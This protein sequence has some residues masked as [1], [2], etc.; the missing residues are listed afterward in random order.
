MSLDFANDESTTKLMIAFYKGL[1]NG[2]SKREALLEAQKELR[3]DERF[4]KGKFW[5]PFILLD[6]LD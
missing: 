3:S 6:A 4:S 5:A 2:L 1:A